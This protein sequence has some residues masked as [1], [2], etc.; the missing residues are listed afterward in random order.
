MRLPG[1]HSLYARATLF[2]LVGGGML[3]GALAVLYTEMVD[4]SVERLLVERVE[5]ART[6]GA[7][8]EQRIRADLDHLEARIRRPVIRGEGEDAVRRAL[9]RAYPASLFDEGAFVLT[10]GGEPLLAVPSGIEELRSAVDL[11]ALARRAAVQERPVASSLV[12]LS[13][14]RRP[15]IMTL[16]AVR[17]SEGEIHA[18]VGGLLQPAS[19]DLLRGI[20][21]DRAKVPTDLQLVDSHG[22]VIAST[23]REALYRRGDHDQVLQQAVADGR[24]FM[25]RCHSCHVEGSSRERRAT[26]VMSFA[27]LPTLDLGVAVYQP[28]SE[29]LAPAVDLRRQ[30]GFATGIVALFVLFVGF[31]VHSV[32]RPVVRLT[33][34]VQDLEAEEDGTPLPRLGRDEI[35]QLGRALERWRDRMMD[36]L[37]E[38]ESSRERLHA[39]YDAMRRHLEA[40]ED[41]A[42]QSALGDSVERVL[43]RGLHHLA[44]TVG[45]SAGAVRL[46]FEERHY[47]VGCGMEDE[48]RADLLARCDGLVVGRSH[49]HWT[50]AGPGRCTVEVLEDEP[51]DGGGSG[52]LVLTRLVAPDGHEIC[53][54]LRDPQGRADTNTR[55][56][57]SLI[58][59]MFLSA[60]TRLLRDQ[61]LLRQLQ[62]E[63]YLRGVLWAQEAERA[64]IARDLHDTIAQDLAA[65][66]LDLERLSTHPERREVR[67]ELQDL[68]RRTRTV[69]ETTREIL[70]DLRLTVLE[71]MGFLPTLQWHLERLQREHDLRGT[72]GVDGEERPLDYETS[73]ILLRIFQESIH[74]VVQHAEADQVFVTVDFGDHEIALTVEDDGR[75]FE[76]DGDDARV[77][78]D[79]GLGLLGMEERARLLG[80]TLDVRSQPGDGTSVHVVVPTGGISAASG[81]AWE[82]RAGT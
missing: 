74:N 33:R 18:F 45:L 29:V 53:S 46:S 34:A 19:A 6:V 36:S 54:A 60:T 2:L 76:P 52:T 39:E 64:R 80:G 44:Q 58:H 55:W 68:E 43:E 35:G 14:G 21:T 48:D 56:I 63:R 50:P 27:P 73:V 61:D 7:L 23:D 78:P 57:H 79:S 72:L 8:L 41:L 37:D 51:T 26:D 70:L 62:Q 32:V 47:E 82:E 3:H 75:G 22:V 81:E 49:D 40:L 1:R 17:S 28:E 13:M 11:G 66:R 71:S 10:P 16:A 42:A 31:S 20:A 24:P 59:H 30:L 65:L 77:A 4:Q 15:V 69:L 9:V 25:G 38:A 12:H 67:E 5:Y